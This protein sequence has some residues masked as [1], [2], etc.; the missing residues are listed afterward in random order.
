[1]V[2]NFAKT[3]ERDLNGKFIKPTLPSIFNKKEYRKQYFDLHK[4]EELKRIIEWGRN[5]KDKRKVAKDKWRAKNK[6]LTNFL[7][8]MYN[9]RRKGAKGYATPKQVKELYDKYLGLCAYCNLN[10][11]NSLDH[12]VPLVRG[13]SNDIENLAPACI[14]CNSSKGD[15]LL[16]EWEPNARS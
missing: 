7:T 12:I 16:E 1:M 11:A 15:K 3:R 2:N 5:N 9:Y 6:P 14:S 8:R 4:K 10:V 13:G